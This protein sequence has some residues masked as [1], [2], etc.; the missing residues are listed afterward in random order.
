LTVSDLIGILEK[1]YDLD[2]LMEVVITDGYNC[3]SY[4]GDFDIQEFEGTV[5]IGIG[6]LDD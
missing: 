3:K 4:T 6:G 5:D 1:F 2:P